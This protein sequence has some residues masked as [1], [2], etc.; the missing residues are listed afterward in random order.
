M[1]HPAIKLDS[2]HVESF[3]AKDLMSEPKPST[4]EKSPPKDWEGLIPVIPAD[5]EIFYILDCSYLH[6]IGGR[7]LFA[8]GSLPGENVRFG[9]FMIASN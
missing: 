9:P 2:T 1:L 3:N 8:D 7:D 6:L 5:S 4:Q